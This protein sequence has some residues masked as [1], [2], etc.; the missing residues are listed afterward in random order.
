MRF[1]PEAKHGANNGLPVARD[2]ME[3]VKQE[4]SWISYG[5]LWTLG[6][7]AAVQVKK[8]KILPITNDVVLTQLLRP[9]RKWLVLKFPG[10]QDALM[11]S[12]RKLLPMAVSPMLLKGLTI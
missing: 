7:V 2:L 8:K 6:G 1:D 12:R 10:A 5:D 11:V 4:F 9:D 3:K